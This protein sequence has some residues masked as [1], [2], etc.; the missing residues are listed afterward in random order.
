MLFCG[1][2]V[3]IAVFELMQLW[4]LTLSSFCV[5]SIMTSHL[6]I[7]H[8]AKMSGNHSPPCTSPPFPFPAPTNLFP[9]GTHWAVVELALFAVFWLIHLLCDKNISRVID[10]WHF[11]LLNEIMLKGYWFM[12]IGLNLPLGHGIL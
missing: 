3:V 6:S 4:F 12:G 11:W 10:I 7:N 2:F 9:S 1:F 5:S 8:D